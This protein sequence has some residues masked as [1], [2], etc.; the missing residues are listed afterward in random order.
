MERV[1]VDMYL[2]LHGD[3]ALPYN[4]VAG[5]EGIPSFDQK[6]ESLETLFKSTLLAITPEFQ[7][8]YG[9]PKD[10]PGEANLTVASNAVAEKF[11]CMA[12][13]VEMPFKDNANL[14]D[15][16]YGWSP[17]RSIQFGEDLLVATRAVLS[18]L[19]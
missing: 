7:V 14:P 12:L 17:Q 2:D 11:N 15:L 18:Q 16:A 1:G 13:T 3:E 5:S 6:M 9:Y 19:S 10:P 4:F 8:E